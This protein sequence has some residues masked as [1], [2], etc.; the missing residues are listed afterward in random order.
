MFDILMLFFCPIYETQYLLNYL[1]WT[2]DTQCTLYYRRQFLP[3][4]QQPILEQL[5][6][7]VI[8]KAPLL[9]RV[10]VQVL[11]EGFLLVGEANPENACGE[12]EGIIELYDFQLSNFQIKLSSLI[13]SISLP[14]PAPCRRICSLAPGYPPRFRAPA[15]V[16]P[17]RPCRHLRA[18]SCPC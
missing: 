17:A 1:A 10:E 11:V 8:I 13:S 15:A 5:D 12:Q 2:F 18:S 7:V 14:Y 4:W 6:V 16:R 3:L 9:H